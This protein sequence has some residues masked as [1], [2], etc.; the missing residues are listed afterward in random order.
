MYNETVLIFSIFV[1]SIVP[2]KN[3]LNTKV[4]E[5]SKRTYTFYFSPLM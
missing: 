5:L 2:Q 4:N 3:K 1:L